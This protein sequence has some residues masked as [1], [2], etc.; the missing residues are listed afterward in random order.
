MSDVTQETLKRLLHYNRDTGIFIWRCSRFG[1]TQGK[2]AGN[3]RPDG[4][5]RIKIDG[6]LYLAHRLAWLYMTGTFPSADTDHINGVRD[7]NRWI[8]LRAVDRSENMRNQEMYKNNTSGVV[9]VSR[10]PGTGKWQA[11]IMVN[12][13]R[14][15]LGLYEHIS[16]ARAARRAAEIEHNFHRNHGRPAICRKTSRVTYE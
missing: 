14:H 4:Y 7:D 11:G 13:I 15:Y 6:K 2:E 10:H 12:G 5:R 8:N 1:V 16:D 3:L 9:G